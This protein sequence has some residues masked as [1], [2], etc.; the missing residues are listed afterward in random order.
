MRL[1]TAF[2]GLVLLGVLC[3]MPLA[4]TGQVT[5]A[6]VRTWDG[7]TLQL[8]DPRFELLYTIPMPAQEG[9][10]LPDSEKRGVSS[11]GGGRGVGLFA[12][13]DSL[14]S[15]GEQKSAQAV[16]ASRPATTLLLSR[17]GV[18]MRIPLERIASLTFAR[19]P[20]A[21]ST[22]PPYVRASHFLYA[23]TAVLRDG[24]RIE[25]TDVNLGTL[26]IRGTTAAGTVDIPW[27]R[28][29]SLRLGA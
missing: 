28:I 21:G 27:E 9:S 15:L 5:A 19:Q 13:L 22:L 24:S 7:T 26:V 3:V 17:A 29:A 25:A 4:A 10:A 16:D 23:A 12:S 1:I 14:K 2:A 20:W 6:E 8:T 11:G 18:T